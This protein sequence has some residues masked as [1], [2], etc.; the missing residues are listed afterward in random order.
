MR[1][2]LTTRPAFGH[3]HPLKPLAR[4]TESAG[5]EVAVATGEPF[6]ARIREAGFTAFTA[7]LSVDRWLRLLDQQFGGREGIARREY[8]SVFFGQV[9]PDFEVPARLRGLRKILERWQPDLL[10]HAVSKF[11]G[12]IAATLAGIPH[13]TCGYGPLLQPDVAELAGRAVGRHWDAAGLNPLDGRM[14]R[15]LYLDP[16]PP[17]LQV[18]AIAELDRTLQIRP[19]AAD[20]DEGMSE[21]PRFTNRP[22]AHTVYFT[23]G[24]IFNSDV[25]VFRTV[26]DALADQPVNVIATLGPGVDPRVLTPAPDNAFWH[27][28]YRR[29]SYC[30]TATWSSVTAARARCSGRSRLVCPCCSCRAGADNFYNA[31]RVLAAGAGRRLLDREITAEAVVEQ[32]AFM[33]EDDG[34]RAGARTIAKEI[35]AMP[36]PAAAVRVLEQ[37]A[38]SPVSTSASRTH[39]SRRSGPPPREVTVSG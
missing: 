18:P 24:T 14:Y 19:Q 20:P 25:E 13:A 1:V 30:R 35:S 34:A 12:P 36:A 2:L 22:H 16:C 31:E 11:A 38:S 17:S 9:F 5:H 4:A 8:R 3:W 23:L 27:P 15:S 39:P 21:P 7:G 29:L 33:L 26:L 37:L 32:V 6:P 10:V 28:T